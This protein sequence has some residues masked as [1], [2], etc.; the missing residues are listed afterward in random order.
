VSDKRVFLG[1]PFGVRQIRQAVEAAIA[2]KAALECADDKLTD[3]HLLEKISQ[4]M[5][6]ADLCLFDLTTHNVN[7][8]TEYGLARGMGLSPRI[9]YCEDETYRVDVKLPDVFSDLR[10]M[11]S[12]RYKTFAELEQSLRAYLP[13]L[14]ANPRKRLSAAAPRLQMRL[15]REALNN[16][17]VWMTGDVFNA[18]GSAANRVK[19][20]FAGCIVP[21]NA[22]GPAPLRIGTL[23][24]GEPY[25]KVSFRYDNQS[26]LR[27]PNGMEHILVEYCDEAGQRCEQRGKL[28][29]YEMAN[30]L[31]TYTFDGLGA[32]KK[33]ER[34]TLPLQG[35]EDP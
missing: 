32:P 8:A 11:D 19:A 1:Y 9:L 7:V 26:P 28:L 21:L 14:L 35:L 5:E 27:S 17:T 16:D 24:P 2:D 29:A 25:R 18:G 23:V 30:G 3:L 33:I 15:R 34:F 12:L 13:S 31:Y 20:V 4:Q 10:G 22:R 6:V